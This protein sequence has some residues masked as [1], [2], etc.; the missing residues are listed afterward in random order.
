GQYFGLWSETRIRR[1]EQVQWSFEGKILATGI[2]GDVK[3]TSYGDDERFRD[4]LELD[5]LRGDLLFT[6][7]RTSDT[8]VYHLQ[9]NS[10]KR[11]NIHREYTLTV[12]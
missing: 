2:N 1:G 9:I 12:H 6:S 5:H 8:G 10:S 7:T 3:K 4:R 11:T